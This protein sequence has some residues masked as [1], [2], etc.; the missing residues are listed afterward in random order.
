M[1]NPFPHISQS[2]IDEL[3]ELAEHDAGWRRIQFPRCDTC[4]KPA[5]WRHPAGGL[6]CDKCPRPT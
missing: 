3:R 5:V 6:R 1:S 2:T 4:S